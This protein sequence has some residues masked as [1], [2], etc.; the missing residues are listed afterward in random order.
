MLC[1]I[2]TYYSQILSIK[3]WLNLKNMKFPTRILP[4]PLFD[5]TPPLSPDGGGVWWS[6]IIILIQYHNTN[7]YTEL[8]PYPSNTLSR[9]P[10]S[11][12]F[13]R[14]LC[15]FN[16]LCLGYKGGVLGD[17]ENNCKYSFCLTINSMS[18]E[19]RPPSQQQ[20][21]RQHRDQ[22]KFASFHLAL[23][24]VVASLLSLGGYQHGYP[25]DTE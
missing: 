3:L 22:Q 4:R 24:V 20:Q 8:A 21:G 11:R 25:V 6:Y 12:Y 17:E 9:E 15:S 7:L 1:F 23:L 14:L 2:I 19:P 5:P 18:L 10:G 16:I 13:R